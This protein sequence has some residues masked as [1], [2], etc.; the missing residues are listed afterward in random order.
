MKIR[1]LFLAI[2]LLWCC[3]NSVV[4]DQLTLKNGDRLTGAV[5][6]ALHLSAPIRGR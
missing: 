6:T 4:S 2:T 3:S 5:V 1:S